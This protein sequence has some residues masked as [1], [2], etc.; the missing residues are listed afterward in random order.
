MR[1]NTFDC[2]VYSHTNLVPEY[3]EMD[4]YQVRTPTDIIGQHI[5][6]PKW[7]LTTTDGSGNGWNY[8][9][10]TLSPGAVR[11]RIHAINARNLDRVCN[12]EA[13]IV[14]PA[15]AQNG[16]KGV[17]ATCPVGS[18]LAGQT[19]TVPELHAAAHPY[20]GQFGRADWMGARTTL[21]RWFADP[22]VN[23]GGMDRGLGI[24]FTH[25][26][27][28][29]S[30]HQQIGLYATV[31]TEPAGSTW[32]HNETGTQLGAGP[33]GS[34]G[35]MD[36]GPTSWQAAIHAAGPGGRVPRVLLRVCRLPACL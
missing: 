26:H 4:D 19:V 18:T 17:S 32:V 21:Q 11:E 8:E 3:Y 28:G 15:S 6:L 1:L 12:N 33:G 9:D 23:T 5:H 13:A 10:G 22:V 14:P 29:P 7:D 35:R 24:I 25:D 16:A 36:G 31:L 30:T 34:G 2:A 27:Y 20:F